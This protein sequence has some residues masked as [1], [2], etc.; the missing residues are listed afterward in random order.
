MKLQRVGSGPVLT[1]RAEVAWEKN[2]V[3]NTAAIEVNGVTHLFYRA[4]A[5]NPGDPNRSVIGHAW[6]EDGIH[7]DRAAEP[8]LWSAT[9]PEDAQG[10]EDPRITLL[11]GLY[12][13]TYTAYDGSRTLSSLAVSTDLVHWERRGTLLPFEPFG[14]NKNSALF[15]EKI[16][17]RYCLLHRPMGGATGTYEPNQ[18]YGCY[19]DDVKT[20]DSHR[21]LLPARR[22]QIDWE[23]TK[24]GI[25]GSPHRVDEGWLLV[26]HA[27][28]AKMVYR[29]GLALLDADDPFRI[30]KQTDE[31]ILQPE[32]GWE[33]EG[34][35]NNVVF[36]C[37]SILRGTELSVYY[38][39]ADTVIGLARGDV[40]EFLRG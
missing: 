17:G 11:D 29:L 9:C 31:P 25:G 21:V 13:L 35:V 4:V 19:S 2:A 22:G 12:Y 39:G 40:S 20:F 10:V 15:P 26:Y 3:L 38:G 33:I 36:T 14:S 7:F 28:D 34:D 32:V 30:L 6:S 24:N 8:V 5:H 1:P 18:V 27:V 23:Y 16:G 37:G